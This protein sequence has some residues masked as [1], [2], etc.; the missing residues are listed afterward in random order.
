MSFSLETPIFT[1]LFLPLY[2][3]FVND[4]STLATSLDNS[5]PVLS[6]A[7]DLPVLDHV[8]PLSLEPLTGLDLCRFTWV[9]IPPPY[10][11]NYHCSFALATLYKPHT[12][13]EAHTNPLRQQAVSKEL[14]TLHKNHI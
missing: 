2:P 11:T 10:F 7:H 4:S 14:D 12:Y 8:A 5:S 1:N 3:E 9:S 13:H 6:L